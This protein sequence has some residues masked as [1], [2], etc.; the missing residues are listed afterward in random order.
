M[1][2]PRG[3]RRRP[4]KLSA[5]I[6]LLVVHCVLVGLYYLTCGFLLVGGGVLVYV[7][8]TE[9]WGVAS[10]AKIVGGFVMIVVAIY[11]FVTVPHRIERFTGL[12]V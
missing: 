9:L 12:E 4:E 11:L 5:R 3:K 7:G 10:V 2:R 1:A 8:W 6:G